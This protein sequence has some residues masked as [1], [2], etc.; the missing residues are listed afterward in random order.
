MTRDLFW[1]LVFTVWSLTCATL[2]VWAQDDEVVE[3][4]PGAGQEQNVQFMVADENFDQWVFGGRGNAAA[5]KRRLELMLKLQI[6]GVETICPLSEVQKKKLTL[7]GTADIKRFFE[8]VTALRKKF[9]TVKNDQNKF[10]QFWQDAQPLQMEYSRGTFGDGSYFRKAL[11][12]ILNSEQLEKVDSAENARRTFSYRSKVEAVV[13]S[14]DEVLSFRTEQR[15]K[16]VDLFMAPANLPKTYGTD[17][18]GIYAVM[19]RAAQ[20]PV[21]KYNEFL[22]AAQVQAFQRVLAVTRGYAQFLKN[23]GYRWEGEAAPAAGGQPADGGD[24]SNMNDNQ[25]GK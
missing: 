7:A 3:E 16:L 5:N 12:H 1:G 11:N 9:D 20:I 19:Y 15:R 8:K 14:L 17:S 13:T 24:N 10:N 22:D 6:E 21:E 25:A 2:P 18:Y 4:T 23:A